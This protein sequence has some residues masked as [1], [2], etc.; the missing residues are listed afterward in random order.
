MNTTNAV[1][2]PRSRRDPSRASAKSGRVN[3]PDR[4]SGAAT[5][6]NRAR[7]P[8]AKPTG[9]QSTSTPN[10]ITNPAMPRKDAAERYSPPIAAAFQF[11]LMVRDAT[12][13]SLV[14]RASRTPYVEM[15]TV[16]RLTRITAG[17][18]Y[19]EVSTGQDFSTSSAKSRSFR[20]AIRVY[21]QPTATRNGYASTP[22]SSHGSRMPSTVALA[23]LGAT[24]NSSG[25]SPSP[26]A[27]SAAIRSASASCAR[28]SP[29]TST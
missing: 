1:A 10:F 6:S 3:A 18:A 13:K 2:S 4:R 23:T 28:T 19:G 8:A 14:V 21:T 25:S 9:Y 11:G 5:K 20:S 22:S 29:R 12:R 27:T 15:A 16:T 7:Y 17:R 26:T 24:A